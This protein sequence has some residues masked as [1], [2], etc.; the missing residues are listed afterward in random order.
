M[1]YAIDINMQIIHCCRTLWNP[2]NSVKYQFNIVIQMLN[3]KI[4]Q[5]HSVINFRGAYGNNM[6]FFSTLVFF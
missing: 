2:A 1:G 6:I 3:L 5:E 4:K